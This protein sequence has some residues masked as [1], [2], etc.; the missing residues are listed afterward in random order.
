MSFDWL[1][2]RISV[3]I[4]RYEFQEFHAKTML[5]KR[6][7]PFRCTNL[8]QNNPGQHVEAESPSALEE[9]DENLPRIAP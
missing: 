9:N 4:Q 1:A 8:V 5:L 7:A 6:K 3:S 2:V